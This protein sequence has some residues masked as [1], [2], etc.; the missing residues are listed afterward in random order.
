LS[1]RL[2]FDLPLIALFD[3]PTP[4]ELVELIDELR[5]EQAERVDDI[6]PAI[7]EWV[8][9]LQPEGNGRPIFIFP[10]G[11]NEMGALAIDARIAGFVGRR[12]PFW[13]LRRDHP[14]LDAARAEGVPAL[15]RAYVEQM[16]TIQGEGP[17][18]LFANC[19]GGYLAWETARLLLAA[20]EEVAGILFYE[21]PLR[22]DFDRLLPGITP[23]HA[24]RPW[25]LSQV[26]RP[27]PLPVDLIHLMTE[28]WYDRGWWMPWL[29]V[30]HGT[31]ETAVISSA[32]LGARSPRG[33]REELIARHV[34]S[35][36][37]QAE[38][39]GRSA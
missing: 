3:A 27:Q 16:R 19:V 8:I 6:T 26:Y 34:R 13:G 5:A 18:L 31:H 37:A 11:P 15:A 25:H 29:R 21:V 20:G 2:G 12:H 28:G 35:W 14:A 23:A 24:S 32:D 10:A 36:I 33:R 4:V 17:F 9:P 7:P 1:E 38:T 22:A 30:V 39:R